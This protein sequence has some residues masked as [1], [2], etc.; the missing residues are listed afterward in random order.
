VSNIGSYDERVRTFDWSIA[1]QELEHNAGDVIN[2]GWYCADRICGKGRAD[3]LALLWENAQGEEKRY[4]FDDVRVYSNTIG[5]FL[6]RLGVE[7]G[8]R[9]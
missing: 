2:I 7:R 9:V 1:E 5:A 4:T 6:R 8:D 3:Q